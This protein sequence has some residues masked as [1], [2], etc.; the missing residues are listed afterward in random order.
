MTYSTQG[1]WGWINRTVTSN[2]PAVWR[3]PGGAYMLCPNWGRRGADCGTDP[4]EPDQVYRLNGTLVESTPTPTL[5][6]YPN[7][8]TAEGCDALSLS[9]PA[10]EI[11]RSVGARSLSDTIGNFN[12]GV[13]AGALALNTVDSNTAVGA[14]TLLLN[15]RGTQN[16]AVGT[17]AL[18]FNGSG[19]VSGDF[20]TA[21]GYSALMN[22]THRRLQHGYRL[23][24]AHG[25]HRWTS[26][27]SW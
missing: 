26:N 19:D 14:A 20:N 3:N 24:S 1:Q 2:N 10:L 8:T 7:F 16:T 12:T 6:C 27:G 23:G 21:T 18:L 9:L 25:Q 5:G 4:S 22:N 13:G 11:Q 15:S 17:D